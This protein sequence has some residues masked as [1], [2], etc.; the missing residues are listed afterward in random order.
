MIR[1]KILSKHVQFIR[2]VSTGKSRPLNLIEASMLGGVW[3]SGCNGASVT[4][5][6][7]FGSLMTNDRS[8]THIS[9]LLPGGTRVYNVITNVNRTDSLQ[10]GLTI[11]PNSTKG[12]NFRMPCEG[13]SSVN[14]TVSIAIKQKMSD[15]KL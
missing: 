3:R 9:D 10:P 11:A 1:L 6:R 5:D 8:G 4:S 13:S 15:V 7:I 14:A 2:L 12:M